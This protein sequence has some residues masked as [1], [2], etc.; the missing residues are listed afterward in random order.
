M[1]KFLVILF[2]VLPMC[3]SA[4]DSQ[5]SFAEKTL[6]ETAQQIS[7]I[8]VAILN[9]N[10]KQLITELKTESAEAAVVII[11]DTESKFAEMRSILTKAKAHAAQLK[12]EMAAGKAIAE[13]AYSSFNTDL[14]SVQELQKESEKKENI[15]N[16]EMWKKLETLDNALLEHKKEL[17]AVQ[18]E[19]ARKTRI[20]ANISEQVNITREIIN[21]VEPKLKMLKNDI[22]TQKVNY[23]T[24]VKEFEE[25]TDQF[26]ETL[27][28]LGLPINTRVLIT[29]E[30]DFEE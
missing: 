23:P 14:K 25:V 13:K 12:T 15:T 19:V 4:L 21:I 30:S 17:K 7:D 28:R 16:D 24:K 6:V 9:T 27:M 26:Q 2:V 10:I 8:S 11:N 5:P 18:Q 20:M 1:Y 3:A 29:V 22:E